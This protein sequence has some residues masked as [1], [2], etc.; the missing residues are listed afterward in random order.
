MCIR[1]RNTRQQ[2]IILQ[3]EALQASNF[4]RL[5][6]FT[7]ANYAA[8]LDLTEQGLESILYLNESF[9]KKDEEGKKKQFENNK[10]LQIANA[11]ISTLNSI[12]AIFSNAAKNPTTIP[13]PAYPYIQAGLAG[14][15]GFANVQRIR[16]TQYSGGSSSAAAPSI[17][18]GAPRMT[19]GS[20]LPTESAGGG[21]VYVL[22][23]DITRAQQRVNGNQRVST[24]E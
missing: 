18:G 13:F 21:K 1:D 7:K 17:G 15:Y 5:Q 11:I 9:S 14:V 23:G 24:V 16:N 12:V 6:M 2:E 19:I 3:S 20:S 8:I 4:E 10:K 22:E